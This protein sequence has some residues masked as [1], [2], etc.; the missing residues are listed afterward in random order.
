MLKEF[1]FNPQVFHSVVDSRW[2]STA[3]HQLVGI[4]TYYGKHYST[5]FFH[6][7]LRVWIY[8]DDAAVREVR[9]KFYV[10]VSINFFI[11]LN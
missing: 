1:I 7:K 6:T 9:N 4:V 11:L 8:F 2:A 5:F 10:N 3:T